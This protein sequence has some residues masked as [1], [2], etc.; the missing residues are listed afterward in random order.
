MAT[1]QVQAVVEA[2]GRLDRGAPDDWD[3]V[4]WSEFE[5]DLPDSYAGAS[6][7]A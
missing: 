2:L 1:D 5:R 6:D 4:D 3:D 7:A